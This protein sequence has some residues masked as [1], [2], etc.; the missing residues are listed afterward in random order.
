[1]IA[2]LVHVLY[3]SFQV[4][5]ILLFNAVGVDFCLRNW[6]SSSSS[7]LR[8]DKFAPI[9]P[10]VEYLV[11]FRFVC[12]HM[13]IAAGTVAY[14]IQSRKLAVIRLAHSETFFIG[15][16]VIFESWENYVH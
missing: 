3:A 6:C 15:E 13:V 16:I 11:K 8:L 1:M 9:S 2:K 14:V 5:S 4:R 7:S 12:L 10:G